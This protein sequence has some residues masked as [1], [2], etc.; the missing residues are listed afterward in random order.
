MLLSLFGCT[1][2][3]V[4]QPDMEQGN[5]LST[6]QI[7]QLKLGMSKG[8]VKYLLGTPLLQNTFDS[9]RWYYVYTMNKR[10]KIIEKK[11]LSLTFS[12]DKLVAIK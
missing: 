11:R 10:G 5:V 4:Y 7:S 2:F 1:A 6:E 12:N 3:H 9:N 8:E